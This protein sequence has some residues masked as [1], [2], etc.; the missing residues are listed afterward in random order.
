[1]ICGIPIDERSESR[2]PK[3]IRSTNKQSGTHIRVGAD[4]LYVYK[5]VMCSMYTIIIHEYI[6]C[7]L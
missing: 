3:V 2:S 1:M 7:I 4:V 5:T 6:L